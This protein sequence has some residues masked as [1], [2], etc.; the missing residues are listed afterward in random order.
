MKFRIVFILTL[1]LLLSACNMTL[2]EDITPPPGYIPPTPVPTLAGY[3]PKAPSTANGELIYAEKCAACHG[4]TGMGDG[5]QGIQLS[6]PVSAFGLP[7]IARGASL[8]QYYAIVTRGNIERFMP[9]FASLS[10]QERWDAAAYALTLHSTPAQIQRGKELFESHCVNCSTD[11]FVDQQVMARLS[12]TDVARIVKQGNEK[13]PA[14]G[15]DF[16]DDDLWATAAYLRTLSFDLSPL[17]APVVAAETPASPAVTPSEAGATVPASEAQAGAGSVHGSITNKTGT[18]LPSD[19]V[20]TLSGYDHDSKDPNAGPVEVFSTNATVNSDGAYS[21]QNIDMPADRIF[22]ARVK[23][24]GISF[25][26]DFAIAQ[27]D[28]QSLEIP[29]LTLYGVSK[30]ASKLTVDGVQIVFEY[31][32]NSI[33][34][35][36]LYTFHNSTTEVIVVPQDDSGQIPFIKFPE[37]SFGFGFEPMQGSEPFIS[38]DGGFAIAPSDK[39][40]GLVAISALGAGAK[41]DF[42]QSFILPVATVNIFAPAGVKITG[43]NIADLGERTVQNS[44]YQIYQTDAVAAGGSLQFTLSGKPRNAATTASDSTNTKWIIS[45]VALGLAF[46]GVGLWMNRREKRATNTKEH[47]DNLTSTND[48]IDAIIALDDSYSKKKL[49]EQ[50]YHKRRNALKDKLKAGTRE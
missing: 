37:D 2:A 38:T 16:S 31:G 50:A 5:D 1:A 49:S 3:S 34:T 43:S 14:F 4:A 44:D 24:E 20:V 42:S 39:P 29:A 27:E 7:E 13:I 25:Q 47:D 9:P 30:D 41:V 35:Y 8:A 46:I 33:S 23:T 15:A 12:E 45:A 36:S 28:A 32:E 18:D 10:D 17:P 19:L 22:I 11:Y 48:V 21:F 6:V 26:S 40:Y